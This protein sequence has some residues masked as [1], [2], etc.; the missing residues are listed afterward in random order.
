MLQC[1]QL[2]RLMRVCFKAHLMLARNM[3]IL[4][5]PYHGHG[6]ILNCHFI[7]L[8]PFSLKPNS[9]HD[10]LLVIGNYQF[11]CCEPV[12]VFVPKVGL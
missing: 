7:L 12:M 8:M 11:G 5:C 2:Q 4:E 10:Y 1:L 9:G 6:F 3:Q